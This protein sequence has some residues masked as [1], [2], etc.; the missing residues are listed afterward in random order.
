M[1][2]HTSAKPTLPAVSYL[3][4]TAVKPMASWSPHTLRHAQ[5]T[6]VQ[7]TALE[8]VQKDLKLDI[9]T[10]KNIFTFQLREI[11]FN[12]FFSLSLQVFALPVTSPC[13]Q[14]ARTALSLGLL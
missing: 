2:T 9:Y 8:Q 4:S 12:L 14:R 5:E 7:F 3:T 13:L 11:T 10:E 1:D 6:Q